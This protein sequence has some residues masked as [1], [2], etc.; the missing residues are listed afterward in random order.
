VSL[1][2]PCH[3]L[4]P[5]ILEPKPTSDD[6]CPRRSSSRE[7]EVVVQKTIEEKVEVGE[8]EEGEMDEV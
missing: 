5:D 3:L 2:P 7:G 1:A 4:A 8:G 6:S